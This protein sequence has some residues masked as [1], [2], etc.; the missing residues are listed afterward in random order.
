MADDPISLLRDALGSFHEKRVLEVG[1]GG[2]ALLSALSAGGAVAFGIEPGAEAVRRGKQ[3]FP[4]A[5]VVQGSAEALPFPE[6]SFDLV[7][8]LYSLH[9]VPPHLMEEALREAARTVR[10]DGVVI[11]IEPV[12]EG[13]FFE[14]M[15]EVEDETEVRRAAQQRI[16]D[17]LH[18]G[19]LRLGYTLH[20]VWSDGFAS[21]E[22]FFDRIIANNRAR[23][24]IV[25]AKQA[26]L[27]DTFAKVATQRGATYVLD[28]PIRAEVLRPGPQ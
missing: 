27:R 16:A 18:D 25:K 21:A 12:A 15:K 13:S 19:T 20:R 14:A 22:A 1:C 7:V 24:P 6:H 5:F 4:H 10:S 3:A 11:I 2:G 28:Q 23:E 9:H 17:A 26:E 8:F